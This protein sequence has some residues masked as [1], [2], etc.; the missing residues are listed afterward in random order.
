MV[1]GAW[2]PL[3][4]FIVIAGYGVLTFRMFHP[5]CEGKKV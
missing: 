2:M 1:G 3:S 4:S 5:A